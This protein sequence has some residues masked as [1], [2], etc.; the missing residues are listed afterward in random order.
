[1]SNKLTTETYYQTTTE[2]I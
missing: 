2:S 1:M